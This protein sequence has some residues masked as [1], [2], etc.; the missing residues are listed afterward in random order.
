MRDR[1]Q[2]RRDGD[3][4]PVMRET[5]V[6]KRPRGWAVTLVVA[7]AAVLGT[8]AA[9][10]QDAE[11]LLREQLQI[12]TEMADFLAGVQD[13]E[14]FEARQA[15]WNSKVQRM[16]SVENRLRN[17][18]LSSAESERLR[19]QVG[20]EL[21][22]AS[23]RLVRE[24]ERLQP[25]GVFPAAQVADM[26]RRLEKLRAATE[27]E[28]APSPKPPSP[29]PSA[30][31]S[32]AP[33]SA[34]AATGGFVPGSRGGEEKQGYAF[35]LNVLMFVIIM[36]CAGTLYTEGMWG[37]AVRL[38]DVVFAGLLATNYWEPLSRF[39]EGRFP[40]FTF[41]W[42][43]LSLWIVFCVSFI[44]LRVLTDFASRVKVRFLKIAEQIGSAFFALWIGYVMV[45]FTMFTL[46]T[47]PLGERFMGGGFQPGEGNFILGLAPDLQWAGFAQKM[48]RGP[49]SRGLAEDELDEYGQA[50]DEREA[51]T[52]VFD[53]EGDFVPK[54]AARR[55]WLE[56]YIE[57]K[58]TPRMSESDVVE[59]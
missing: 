49:F 33:S 31:A 25:L 5:A 20:S 39:L 52:A 54:Y 15:E 10:G 45:C 57:E 24:M 58:S 9:N 43:F 18:P 11:A 27:S 28:P 37:N 3:E 13:R 22:A 8:T 40:T 44:V 26:R 47:A 1:Q 14:S 21:L 46:H 4:G 16:Q 12:T 59:R 19:Q 7:A 34:P 48:S 56:S 23:E 36:A 32:A 38:V 51:R 2:G 29:G 17:A 50:E 6:L 42:D 41:F 30:P 55:R 35:V 53:R